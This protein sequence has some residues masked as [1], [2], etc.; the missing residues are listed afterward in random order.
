[1]RF[2]KG[3]IIKAP[4]KYPYV[5]IGLDPGSE[6]E[7]VA[8][9]IYVIDSHFPFDSRYLRDTWDLKEDTGGAPKKIGSIHPGFVDLFLGK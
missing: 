7:C 6:A 8:Y 3:D 2:K 4:L 5:I 1:M 9:L